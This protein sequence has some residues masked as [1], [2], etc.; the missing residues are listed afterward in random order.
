MGNIEQKIQ[1]IEERNQRVEIDKAWEIS[2]TRRV[3]LM[4]FTYIAIGAYMWAIEIAQPWLN[5]VIPTAAF[6]LSTLTMPL[7]KK[8]WLKRKDKDKFPP[9]RKH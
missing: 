2:W 9:N 4:I 8:L 5:A 7:F 6:M 3:L 1:K